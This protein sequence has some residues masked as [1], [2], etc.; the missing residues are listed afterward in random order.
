MTVVTMT[1]SVENTDVEPMRTRK[2]ILWGQDNLLSESVGFFLESSLTWD[3]IRVKSDE[4]VDHLFEETKRINPEVV[5]LC[6]DRTLKDSRLPLRLIHE[7]NCLRVVT[8]SLENNQIQ[9]HSKHNVVIQGVSDLLS[10]V[11]AGNFSDCVP[12]KEAGSKKQI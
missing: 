7:Q 3:V 5:I 12:G 4:D 8:V 1:E 6:T 2:A 11:E 9:V 10:I